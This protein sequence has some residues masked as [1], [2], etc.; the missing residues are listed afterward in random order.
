[1]KKYQDIFLGNR[2]REEEKERKTE[3]VR[4][5]AEKRDRKEERERFREK[6]QTELR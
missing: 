5:R 2:G 3:A 6:I 4:Y 1:M